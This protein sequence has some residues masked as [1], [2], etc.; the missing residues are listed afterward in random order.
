[1]S[2]GK[3]VDVAVRRCVERRR[4]TRGGAY[5]SRASPRSCRD[6]KILKVRSAER[7]RRERG[8]STDGPSGP[9]SV[10]ERVPSK[11]ISVEAGTSMLLVSHLTTSRELPV[12]APM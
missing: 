9:V 3:T 5:H 1:M 6:E 11:T 2:P 8:R 7:K 10:M 4:E 12:K